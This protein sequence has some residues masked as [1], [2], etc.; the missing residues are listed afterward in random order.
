MNIIIQ[1]IYQT[2]NIIISCIYTCIDNNSSD[3]FPILIFI[4]NLQTI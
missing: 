2:I 4:K 1:H 3:F